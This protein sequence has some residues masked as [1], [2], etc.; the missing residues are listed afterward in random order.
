M[1]SYMVSL[2][3]DLLFDLFNLPDDFD[4]KIEKAFAEYT[5]GTSIAYRDDDRLK[6]IDLVIRKVNCDP[7]PQ[8]ETENA[9]REF[10]DY[11]D[12][13]DE[14]QDDIYSFLDRMEFDIFNF[15]V[16]CYERG[17]ENARLCSQYHQY[18]HHIYDELHHLVARICKLVM[19]YE[20]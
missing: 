13:Y 6:F 18:D 8:I 16:F 4:A 19:N 10:D 20:E 17:A 15:A 14:D 12:D 7:Q 5:K 9:L 2:P 1:Q 3:G 11:F